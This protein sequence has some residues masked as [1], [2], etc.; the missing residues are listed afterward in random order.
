MTPVDVSLAAAHV[1][2]QCFLVVYGGIIPAP[3]IRTCKRPLPA[4][5]A[6]AAILLR[7]SQP[8]PVI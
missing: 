8:R 1:V 3:I 7:D 4:T 5:S 2:Q 6:V